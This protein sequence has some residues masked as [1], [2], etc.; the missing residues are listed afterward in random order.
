MAFP[1][2]RRVVIGERR[3][4]PLSFRVSGCL[5]AAPNFLFRATINSDLKFHTRVKS[6][7]ISC[8]MLRGVRGKEDFAWWKLKTHM[9]LKCENA[10]PREN[11]NPP[12]FPFFSFSN[13]DCILREPLNLGICPCGR[14]WRR[15]RK[16][17]RGKERKI[18]GKISWA[19]KTSEEEDERQTGDA[20]ETEYLNTNSNKILTVEYLSACASLARDQTS[21]RGKK[22]KRAGEQEGE[23]GWKRGM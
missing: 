10:A 22:I 16:E 5:C 12:A 8:V 2:A 11:M 23:K 1:S 14:P 9:R 17:C 4:L 3:L 18:G 6:L 19:S 15:Q 7:L 21:E 13:V 20:K